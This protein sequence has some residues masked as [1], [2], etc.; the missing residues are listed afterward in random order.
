MCKAAHHLG[1]LDSSNP[2][3]WRGKWLHHHG[4]DA[5]C[6]IVFFDAVSCGCPHLYVKSYQN[7]TLRYAYCFTISLIGVTF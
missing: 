3:P 2:C 7:I 5:C 4:G 1:S 6:V